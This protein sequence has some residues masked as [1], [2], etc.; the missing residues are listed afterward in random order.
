MLKNNTNFRVGSNY[1][2][3][4]K[5]ASDFLKKE[6]LIVASLIKEGLLKE[7]CCGDCF[8]VEPEQKEQIK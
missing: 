3:Q 1:L 6:R 8:V 5:V 4:S 2:I 7:T